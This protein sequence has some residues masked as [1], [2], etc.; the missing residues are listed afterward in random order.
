[1]KLARYAL[2]GCLGLSLAAC[3]KA[4]KTP[5]PSTPLQAREPVVAIALGGRGIIRKNHIG[6]LKVL[7]SHGI[8]SKN[9]TFS[10]SK[11]P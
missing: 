6:V 11:S 4:T 1:M 3:D 9:V 10:C 2:I 7:E 5:A 8:K